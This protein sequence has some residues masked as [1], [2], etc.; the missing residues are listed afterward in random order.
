MATE[1]EELALIDEYIEAK[2]A[3]NAHAPSSPEPE[4]KRLKAAVAAL[5][6]AGGEALYNRAVEWFIFGDE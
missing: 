3:L 5:K 2:H 4:R 6:E 1:A